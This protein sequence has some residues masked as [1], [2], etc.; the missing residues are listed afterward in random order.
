MA[1]LDFGYLLRPTIGPVCEKSLHYFL[2]HGC[3]KTFPLDALLVVDNERK[4]FLEPVTSVSL[5][6]RSFYLGFPLF[7]CVVC[8]CLCVPFVSMGSTTQLL[9]PVLISFWLRGYDSFS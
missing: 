8:V 9:V 2:K 6:V 7:Q 3:V 1:Y 5:S 4:S